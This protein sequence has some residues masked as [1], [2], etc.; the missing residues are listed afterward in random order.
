MADAEP[1]AP[2][3][4][5]RLGLLPTVGVAAYLFACFAVWALTSPLMGVPDEPAHTVKAASVW[6]GQLRGEEERIE[7]AE[8]MSGSGDI[9]VD[10]VEVP[11]AYASAHSLPGCYA[12]RPDVPADCAP[13]L[14]EA[15]EM[16]ESPTT[17]GAYPP[18]F[19]ALVGWPSRLVQNDAGAYLMRL[20]GAAA[21]ALLIAFALRSLSR[22]VPLS[23][24]V[25]A[26]VLA[27]T[28][29]VPFLMGSINPA[30]LEIAAALLFWAALVS[31]ALTWSPGAPLDKWLVAEVL[32][33]FAVLVGTRS[34]GIVFAGLALVS[35]AA[36]AGFRRCRDLVADRKVLLL[37]A[38][39]AVVAAAAMVWVLV[40]GHLSSVPGAPL[41]PGA[42]PVVVLG[43]ALDDFLRQMVAVLGWKDTPVT[44]AVIAWAVAASALL[45]ATVLL[46]LA[47]RRG[48]VLVAALAVVLLPVV[49]QM[50]TLERDGLAWQGRYLLPFA[51]GVPMLAVVAIAP[52]LGR[53]RSGWRTL[54]VLVTGLCALATAVS[55]YTWLRRSA[56][57]VVV[58]SLNPLSWEGWE[59]PVP[60]GLLVLGASALAAVPVVAVALLTR[61]GGEGLDVPPVPGVPGARS[62]AGPAD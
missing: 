61:H 22:A 46:G 57:G 17:A 2:C 16:T 5:P 25:V 37:C 48:V 6:H 38:V 8:G 45:G 28:P 15:G 54:A 53:F 32:V 49:F 34:L 13:D 24:A 50:G 10:V 47:W 51:V 43:G 31:V 52:A 29:M 12:F 21:G 14:P 44:A 36:F 60:S 42:R 62:A 59:P 7:G 33:G 41:E 9:V 3:P 58:D 40:A 1:A 26:F 27:A 55:H 39:G 23:L 56:I 35:V 30:G 20:A 4:T 18:L 11:R 19:Y